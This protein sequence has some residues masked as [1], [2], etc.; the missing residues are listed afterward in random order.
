MLKRGWNNFPNFNGL[1]HENPWLC[2]SRL[3]VILARYY[4]FYAK[5]FD[6]DSGYITSQTLWFKNQKMNAIKT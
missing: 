1:H 4:R 5:S 6:E 2:S 3:L